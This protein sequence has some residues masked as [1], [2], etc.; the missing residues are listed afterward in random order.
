M[1]ALLHCLLGND[2]EL[3]GLAFLT[4]QDHEFPSRNESI[5]FS[6]V[7]LGG[8]F[9]RDVMDRDSRP[10]VQRDV[11]ALCRTARCGVWFSESELVLS[12]SCFY[13]FTWKGNERPAVK[14][15]SC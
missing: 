13:V 15:E 3:D 14:K 2:V 1:I 11:F 6:T 8:V 10:I 12:I 4:P 9:P 5:F 7:F